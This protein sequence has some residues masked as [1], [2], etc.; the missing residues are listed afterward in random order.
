MSTA[1]GSGLSESREA[2]N[3]FRGMHFAAPYIYIYI[4]ICE[5]VYISL[6]L[7]IYIYIYIYIYTLRCMVSKCV[8]VEL[9]SCGFGLLTKK[10]PEYGVRA[11][12]FYGNLQEQT[13]C[14]FGCLS[15]YLISHLNM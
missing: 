1:F 11:P 14:L 7:N 13:G 8:L 10:V 12:A 6:S 3:G 2:G 15:G 4:Y 9:I 5:Y